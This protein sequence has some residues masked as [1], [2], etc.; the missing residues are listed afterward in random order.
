MVIHGASKALIT[1][2]NTPPAL[3]PGVLV[4]TRAGMDARARLV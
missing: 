2:K 1:E 4:E 3:A